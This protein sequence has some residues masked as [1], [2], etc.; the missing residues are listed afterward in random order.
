MVYKDTER[1]REC[2]RRWYVRHKSEAI[3]RVSARR[4]RIKEWFRQYKETLECF[5]CGED[6]SVCLDFHHEDRNQK[7]DC[8]CVM[9]GNGNSKERI[10]SEVAKCV[11]LCANCHRKRHR[12]EIA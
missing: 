7:D 12:D 6:D 1:R 2:S 5:E 10:L 3:D 9:V 11:V 4:Q 8:V